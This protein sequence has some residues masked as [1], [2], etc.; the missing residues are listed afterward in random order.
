MTHCGHCGA[1][2]TPD[3][4][5]AWLF[6]ADS[7]VCSK[8]CQSARIRSITSA[9]PTLEFPGNWQPR[10]PIRSEP[11]CGFCSKPAV[12]LRCPWCRESDA[13]PYCSLD[14]QRQH[15]A[16]GHAMV[17]WRF[18]RAQPTPLQPTPSFLDALKDISGRVLGC[19]G[20]FR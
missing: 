9:D 13:V 5:K 3:P 14:C 2:I 4:K 17:C 20:W 19:V 1:Q 16:S 15:W 12:E 6:A 7:R 18:G 8:A 11:H 10:A